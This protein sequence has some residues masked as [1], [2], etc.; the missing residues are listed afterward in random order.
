MRPLH[1]PVLLLLG[2]SCLAAA[3]SL[4]AATPD[5]QSG[6]Y[7]VQAASDGHFTLRPENL[8]A[9][10]S[11]SIS[12][13]CNNLV[14]S[15]SMQLFQQLP[16]SSGGLYRVTARMDMEP[17]AEHLANLV[18]SGQNANMKVLLT[19]L[20]TQ[21][22]NTTGE[23]GP[24]PDWG[25]PTHAKAPPADFQLWAD[26]VRDLLLEMQTNYGVLPDYVEFWN[27]P[28]LDI[29][30]TGTREELL[31]LYETLAVTLRAA[32]PNHEF[33]IGG[34]GVGLPMNTMGG[35]NWVL[36]EMVSRSSANGI[37][38]DFLS[39]HTYTEPSTS[40]RFYPVV[41]T[42]RADLAAGGLS[43]VE[44][45]VTEWNL[46]GPPTG[47]PRAIEHDTSHAAANMAGFLAAIPDVGLDGHT[48]FLLQDDTGLDK[49]ITDLTGAN[50]GAI[51]RRGV[52]K[53]AW[54]I[55][56]FMLPMSQEQR[57]EVQWP[58]NEWA[59]SVYATRSG[60]RVRVV[61][62]NDCLEPDWVWS[63]GCK[64]RG[65]LPGKLWTAIVVLNR[66]GLDVTYDNLL[67]T[68]L[69]PYEANVALE[70]LAL[71]DEA[72]LVYEQ[73]RTIELEIQGSGNVSMD[74]V[75]RFDSTHNNPVAHRE[76][77]LPMLQWVESEADYQAWMA[78]SQFL[79]ARGYT[80][81]PYGTEMHVRTAEDLAAA[82][83][84]P[85]EIADQTMQVYMTTLDNQRMAHVDLL[86]NLP[87]TVLQAELP[88]D[89]GL[90]LAGNTVQLSIE[91]NAV[92]VL[93]FWYK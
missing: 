32:F 67:K 33:G 80:A 45:F 53:P 43:N 36:Q 71:T 13:I 50:P 83:N 58:Q 75:W 28:D 41:D 19:V 12:G 82:L 87:G 29:F 86:N 22:W 51:T 14:S 10:A 3:P 11:T 8:M 21:T 89:A 72:E 40:M 17:P 56:E 15:Q 69:D 34:L 18:Q 23:I 24:N 39:W 4:R 59:V 65:T 30:W 81:P 62:S 16:G 93:D 46:W 5:L 64:E 42:L 26:T 70:V 63:E 84:I 91:P 88:S 48:F 68:G 52:F 85:L 76:E 6:G 73:P 9:A 27:E 90:T 1:I 92:M 74:R 37:P 57:I 20:G 54:R 55:L 7:R 47:H 61:I 66:N 35:Q 79:Q 77:I 60:D 2:A 31:D 49:A 44:L 38:L 25:L 78:A